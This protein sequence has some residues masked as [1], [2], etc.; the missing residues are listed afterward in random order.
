M[1]YLDI[2]ASLYGGGSM[3]GGLNLEVNAHGREL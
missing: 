3:G 2:G 1:Q